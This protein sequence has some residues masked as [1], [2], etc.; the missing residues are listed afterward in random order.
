MQEQF[1][2]SKL[3]FFPNPQIFFFHIQTYLYNNSLGNS[4]FLEKE[5][6]LCCKESIIGVS[7]KISFKSWFSEVLMFFP[8]WEGNTYVFSDIKLLFEWLYVFVLKKKNH[9][10]LSLNLGKFSHEKKQCLGPTEWKP[11]FQSNLCDL[12]RK[13]NTRFV[14][15]RYFSLILK[16][17]ENLS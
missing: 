6:I 5:T 11:V 1:V 16:G 13:K 17:F 8:L 14:F 3:H 2:H 10:T 7:S 15:H 9:I 4:I 12:S